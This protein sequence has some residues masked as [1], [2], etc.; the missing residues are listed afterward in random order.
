[1]SFDKKVAKH[2]GTDAA[3]ILSNIEFW[4]AKN[5]ANNKNFHD[6]YYW[7]YNSV[8]AWSE[9]FDYLTKSQIR[10]CLDKLESNKYVLTG[11]YNTSTYD[12]TK[13]YCSIREIHLSESS[14]G[15]DRSN[16]PIPYNKPNINTDNKQ[17]INS[18]P[19]NQKN[20]FKA[21]V[22]INGLEVDF[23]I[24][25]GDKL[26]LK[27]TLEEKEKSSAKKEK[28]YVLPNEIEVVD[29]KVV[30]PRSKRKTKTHEDYS[31]EVKVC[32][33]DCLDHFPQDL[34]PN[35]KE[36]LNWLD[37]VDKLNR[38]D[39]LEF[40][41]ISLLVKSV[42]KDVFWSKNFL[43]L[44]KLRSKNKDKVVYWKVFREKFKIEKSKTQ[45]MMELHE[46]AKR[47]LGL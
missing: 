1:M 2:V 43:S 38:L 12:R 3:I 5:K 4:Q 23:E 28:D 30:K 8:S 32:F 44:T 15:F 34:R 18:I 26:I 37:T 47:D 41:D 27:N 33:L 39:G 42:R 14:N 29:P 6:G 22:E 10:R 11:N 20:D 40:S 24:V 35:E 7:T 31:Q 46:Q 21:E 9:L 45:N 16:E 36:S 13:W 19:K 17:N 25:E